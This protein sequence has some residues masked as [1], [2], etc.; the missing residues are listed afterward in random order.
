LKRD[1]LY[2]DNGRA[3]F[4][5][6][7][8]STSLTELVLNFCR[9]DDH[10]VEALSQ[11][12]SQNTH[13]ETLDMG[14][15]YLP[16]RHVAQVVSA[17]VGHPALKSLVL[18][19]NSCRQRGTAAMADLL[20]GDRCRLQDLNLSHQKDEYQKVPLESLADALRTNQTLKNLKLSRNRL[21]CCDIH[22]LL[23]ALQV[24]STLA[25]L[26]LNNN[27]ISDAGIQDI[28]KALP[29]MPGLKELYLV[30]N[31][32]Q[33]ETTS[34]LA[35][36][37]AMRKNQQLQVLEIKQ[38][39]SLASCIQYYAAL[40]WGGRQIMTTDKHVPLGLWPVILERAQTT[41]RGFVHEILFHLLREGP[42]LLD[43][44]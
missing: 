12:L 31:Y 42:A 37:H 11:C 35:L 32:I 24:N 14:A 25:L 33:S 20:R 28:A 4:E 17:L 26:D 7:H 21:L 41:D 13:I 15:C 1:S 5:G 9:F 27:S 30:N 8:S 19:L 40:N 23:E 29:N 43:H 3:L 36:L 44:R 18:T 6:L 39:L 2:G 22:S 10:G 38:S 16:D 34:S